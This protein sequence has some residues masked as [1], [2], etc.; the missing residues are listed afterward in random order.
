M[1]IMRR[2]LARRVRPPGAVFERRLRLRSGGARDIFRARLGPCVRRQCAA[3]RASYCV[4]YMFPPTRAC[5][6]SRLTIGLPGTVLM[7]KVQGPR[8]KTKTS[9]TNRC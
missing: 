7:V 2:R 5:N 4:V 3:P 1:W 8:L 6:M 9:Y